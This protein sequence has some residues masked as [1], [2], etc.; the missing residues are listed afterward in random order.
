MG[1][2]PEWSINK[3]V[4]LL[5]HKSGIFVLYNKRRLYMNAEQSQNTF[6]VISIVFS[7]FNG[8]Y[9]KTKS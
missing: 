7:K 1:K 3:K 5:K 6:D 2:L 8:K 4:I 9:Q